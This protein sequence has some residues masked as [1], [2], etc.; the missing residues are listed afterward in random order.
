MLNF[1]QPILAATHQKE[2][3]GEGKSKGKWLDQLHL[4]NIH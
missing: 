4:E 3:N 2:R 1:H